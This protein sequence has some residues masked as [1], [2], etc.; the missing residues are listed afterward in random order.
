MTSLQSNYKPNST[1]AFSLI[2]LSIVL[3]I[4]AGIVGAVTLG[5]KMLEAAKI[6]AVIADANK[7][8]LAIS[9]FELAYDGLPGDFN[10]ATNFFTGYTSSGTFNG[11]AI[12]D[13]NGNRPKNGNGDGRICCATGTFQEIFY[14]F[15]HLTISGIISGEYTGI[16]NAQPLPGV[17][18]FP[19]EAT[20][21]D[22]GWWVFYSGLGNHGWNYGTAPIYGQEGNIISIGE[23]GDNFLDGGVI[24]ALE[25]KKIDFKIDDGDADSGSFVTISGRQAGNGSLEESGC[26]NHPPTNSSGNTEYEISET[27]RT[28]HPIW[29]LNK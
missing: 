27:E 6:N 20:G 1:K 19:S 22:D 28:C 5:N 10:R 23:S 17:H 25:A 15:H 12:Y 13:K 18:V 11:T 26:V 14:F 16:S 21:A 29:F 7:L 3:I 8:K 9:N 2:E 24:S 4:I